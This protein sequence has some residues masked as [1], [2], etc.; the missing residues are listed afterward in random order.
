MGLY[1]REY[2]QRDEPAGISLGAQR[3]IVTN[4]LIVNVG[5]YLADI[6]L[7]DGGP[8]ASADRVC[9][10]GT[11][12]D[13]ATLVSVIV[14]DAFVASVCCSLP[15]SA[16]PEESGFRLRRDAICPEFG[17]LPR[18]SRRGNRQVCVH[19]VLGHV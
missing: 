16:V 19:E 1:D 14:N 12:L 3:S 13:T 9:P 18:Q 17:L 2:Y 6:L 5:V 15:E 11:G 7:F 10:W 4:L 8:F